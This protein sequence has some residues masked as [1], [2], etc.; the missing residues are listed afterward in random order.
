MAVGTTAAGAG[1]TVVYGLS[2]VT[3][4]MNRTPST[5]FP[6]WTA[7]FADMRALGLTWLRFQLRWKD[8]E[9][10]QGVYSWAVLDDAVARC[11]AAGISIMYTIQG[12]PTWA[13]TTGSQ[14]ASSEPWYLMDA[15][16][17]AGFV[18][19]A[20]SRYNGGAQG[21][22]DALG[23]NEDF[24]IHATS[25]TDILTLNQTITNAGGPYTSLTINAAAQT[26][27]AGTKIYVAGYG[28]TTDVATVA[29]LVNIGG[30]VVAI[31]SFTPAVTYNAGQVMHPAYTSANNTGDPNLYYAGTGGTKSSNPKSQPA[32]SPVFATAVFNAVYAAVRALNA[33]IP[34][35]LPVMWWTQPVNASTYPGSPSNYTAFLQGLYTGCQA[36]FGHDPNVFIDLHYY[37]NATEP[38]V[39]SG[40]VSSII[41]ALADIS[42]VILANGDNGRQVWIT[43]FGWQVTNDIADY[44]TQMIRLTQTLEAMRTSGMVTHVFVYTIDEM[45]SAIDQSS[46]VKWN[47]SLSVYEVGFGILQT[48]IQE[49]PAST[50]GPNPSVLQWWTFEQSGFIAGIPGIFSGR[51]RVLVDMTS[52]QVVTYQALPG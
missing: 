33:T 15:T 5:P 17:A 14:K 13:L 18:T 27:D 6:Y 50:W 37:S 16:L 41:Q 28:N 47:G 46:L 20:L 23:F 1:P 9:T 24:N 43:E 26:A 38:L 21:H 34:L 8:V 2:G 32:R 4:G 36:N 35:G 45:Q 29:S 30:T 10:S 39:G 51:Q 52:M 31:S 25:S 7:L 3:I 22:L 44:Y 12:A 11:N 49:H 40:Q 42:A 19:T 48:Y